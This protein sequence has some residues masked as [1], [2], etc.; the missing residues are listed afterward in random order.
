MKKRTVKKPVKSNLKPSICPICGGSGI[1][2]SDFY[3]KMK[4]L[5]PHDMNCRKCKGTGLIWK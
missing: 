1:I 3:M 2:P 5:D 4:I